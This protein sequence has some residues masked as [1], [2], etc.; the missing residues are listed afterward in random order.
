MRAVSALQKHGLPTTDS[1]QLRNRVERTYAK[2]WQVNARIGEECAV[3]PLP[4]PPQDEE[5]RKANKDYQKPWR[6]MAKPPPPPEQFEVT[7]TSLAGPPATLQTFSV[8]GGPPSPD[9][10]ENAVPRSPAR[11]SLAKA[12]DVALMPRR[13]LGELSA[14]G[15]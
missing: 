5:P 12:L 15:L 14:Q 4:P 10:P 3:P 1:N 11:S 8:P 7:G 13:A 6:H 9:T 2:P